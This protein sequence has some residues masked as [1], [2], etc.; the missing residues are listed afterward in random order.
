MDAPERL[1]FKRKPGNS[2]T[3]RRKRR[4]MSAAF[5]IRHLQNDLHLLMNAVSSHNCSSGRAVHEDGMFCLCR[6][7]RQLGAKPGGYRANR[8]P[9]EPIF[10]YFLSG[11]RG[12]IRQ[13]VILV[14]PGEP[15]Q[16]V[17]IVRRTVIWDKWNALLT[18]KAD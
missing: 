18:A 16:H 1:K 2:E 14:R 8:G 9:D 6:E 17:V 7:E 5:Q 4:G 10:N 12:E 15:Q 11:G 13:S 3:R